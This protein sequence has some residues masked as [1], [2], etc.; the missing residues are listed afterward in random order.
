MNFPL[1]ELAAATLSASS[2]WLGTRRSPWCYPVGLVSVSTYIWVYFGARLYSEV[3]L[4]LVW[5]VMLAMGWRRW[6]QH[7]DRSGH[8]RVAPLA[9]RA[10][11]VQLLLA[12]SAGL[13]LG[14]LMAH[15]T[16]ASLPW[17]D[18][19]LTALS[20]A[21]QFWQNRRHKAAWWLWIA[22][23]LAYIGMFVNKH[24]FITAVL[25]AGFVGLAIKGWRDWSRAERTVD[26]DT[27]SPAGD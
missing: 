21:A 3:L 10:A 22:V 19:M 17:L 8:V 9:V 7:L 13:A 26:A 4:Q 23:D 2:V 12:A 25:Y 1:H 24:L 27:A 14:A 15:R 5:V 16:N 18:A 11:A 20:L 6:L